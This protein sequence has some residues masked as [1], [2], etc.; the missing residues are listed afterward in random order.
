MKN[1]C[2]LIGFLSIAVLTSCRKDFSPIEIDNAPIAK[3]ELEVNSNGLET[4]DLNYTSN[5]VLIKFKR[6][7]SE[8]VRATVLA[9][10]GGQVKE[11]IVTNAMIH[12]GDN[13]GIYLVHTNLDVLEAMRRIK[14][15]EVEYAEPNYIYK[16]S[17]FST[18][19]SYYKSGQLWGLYSPISPLGTT[20]PKSAYGSM[21]NTAWSKGHKGSTS[22]YVGVIDEGVQFDHPDL[23][24]QIW[25]NAND[26]RDGVD[27]DRNGYVDDLRGWD[28]ANGD[29]SIY[30]GGTTGNTDDHGTHVAGTIGA[31][32]NNGGVVGV[33]WYI[34]M[35]SAK[36]LG[37]NGGSL[38]NAIK[39][40][41]YITDLKIRKGLNIIA[42]NNS[43]G[44]G[45]FSQGLLDAITRGAKRNILFIA[46]AGNS[47]V[48]VTGNNDLV[49]NYPSNYNTLGQT[50]GYDGIKCDYDAVIAVA[51]IRSDGNIA[52]FSN[53]G[54]KTVDLGAPGVGI[55]SATAYNGFSAYDGTSMAAPHVSG[56]AALRAAHSSERG[57]LLKNTILNAA[58]ATPTS[59]LTGKTLTGGRLNVSGF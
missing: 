36:F 56:G 43:W 53:Y 11:H 8:S 44:G 58:K 22:V 27:N 23:S 24:G 39:A 59:S 46:A 3:M 48:L 38:V 30:D 13:E 49:P 28:F 2:L 33:N 20:D 40:I 41:D 16:H 6:G 19:D 57:A 31:K 9:G 1:K 52:G 26:S 45:G 21:A 51:A 54:A 32:P 42:T 25:T 18:S 29:N 5:E 55:W 17:T 50:G 4:S 15:D 10:I 12:F 14:E 47:N 37:P 35:I 34:R 7:T